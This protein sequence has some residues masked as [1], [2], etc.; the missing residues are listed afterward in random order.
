MSG[1]SNP[2]VCRLSRIVSA[3]EGRGFTG[4]GHTS[5]GRRRE[6]VV[7]WRRRGAGGT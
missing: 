5:V 4:R 1:Y 3:A 2:L 7:S 6:V